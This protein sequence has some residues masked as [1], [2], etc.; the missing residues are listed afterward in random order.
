MNSH[1]WRN[2]RFSDIL[3]RWWCQI[4]GIFTYVTIRAIVQNRMKKLSIV[5]IVKYRDGRYGTFNRTS[6]LDVSGSQEE[7]DKRINDKISDFVKSPVF[8]LPS[9]AEAIVSISH[10]IY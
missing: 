4:K 8:L 6:D 9:H 5:G 7:V 2:R 10:C 1:H 3:R